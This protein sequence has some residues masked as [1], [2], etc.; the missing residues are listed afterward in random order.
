MPSAW[1]YQLAI[2]LGLLIKNVIGIC[3][4]VLDA[5]KAAHRHPL[6]VKEMTVCEIF[7]ISGADEWDA[8]R[9]TFRQPAPKRDA[10]E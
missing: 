2:V 3:E 10:A 5:L 4:Q 6:L 7:Q 1:G 8:L 9:T